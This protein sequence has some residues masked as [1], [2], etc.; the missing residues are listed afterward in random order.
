MNKTQKES[1]LTKDEIKRLLG[2]KFTWRVG[3]IEIK[4]KENKKETKDNHGNQSQR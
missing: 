3:D 2:D 1:K 4:D